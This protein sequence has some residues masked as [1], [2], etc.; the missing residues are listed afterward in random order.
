[1]TLGGESFGTRVLGVESETN[2]FWVTFTCER[3][4]GDRVTGERRGHKHEKFE[5]VFTVPVQRTKRRFEGLFKATDPL[6]S[7]PNNLVLWGI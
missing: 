4:N 6:G 7:S 3:G 5:V 2:I 1:M